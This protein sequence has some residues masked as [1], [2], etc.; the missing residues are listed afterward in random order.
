MPAGRWNGTMLRERLED[1]LQ[2]LDRREL[3][4]LAVIAVLVVA[5][6]AFWYVRSLPSRVE[7]SSTG[8]RPAT[9][10]ASPEPAPSPVL[11][12]VHVA[13]WVN[14]PGV[15]ELHEGQRVIDA[16]QAAG[17]AKNGA[18]LTTINL[19]A[20]LTDAQ[21]I[22][23]ARRGAAGPGAPLGGATTGSGAGSTELININTATLDQLETLPGIGEVLAQR[24]V[25]YR[26][27]NGP[28]GSVE[29]LLEVSGIG[30]ATL[31]DLKPQ[32]TV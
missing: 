6:A 18:D 13:G 29:D 24:I 9:E 21:Q 25:D 30:D 22:V 20:L 23:V 27:E 8:A 31:A 26:E 14:K 1:R 28:F 15:Y 17:G 4:G 11:L 10:R 12:L 32:I 7:I 5:G 16:I 3:A 2:G 19:A